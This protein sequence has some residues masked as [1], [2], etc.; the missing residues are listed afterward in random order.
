M[1]SSCGRLTREVESL[2]K[3]YSRRQDEC[4]GEWDEM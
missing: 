2:L 4:G 1:M 3:E